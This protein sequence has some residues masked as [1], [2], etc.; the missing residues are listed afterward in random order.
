MTHH[1]WIGLRTS[2]VGKY[3][4]SHNRSLIFTSREVTGGMDWRALGYTGWKAGGAGLWEGL[5]WVS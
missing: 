3:T 4:G 2:E 5:R 1:Y